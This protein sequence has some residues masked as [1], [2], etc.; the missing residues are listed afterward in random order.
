LVNWKFKNISKF[1]SRRLLHFSA[2][3]QDYS[4]LRNDSHY[5]RDG[6]E[7]LALKE[8]RSYPDASGIADF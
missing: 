8:G 3:R 6:L 4:G 5:F 2:E 7:D 1:E